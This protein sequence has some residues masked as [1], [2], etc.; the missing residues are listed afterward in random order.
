MKREFNDRIIRDGFPDRWFVQD[1]LDEKVALLCTETPGMWPGSTCICLK[2]A[3]ITTDE[4]L[5]IARQIARGYDARP[6]AS[7]DVFEIAGYVG[8][9]SLEMLIAGQNAGCVL[10]HAPLLH[11]EGIP[12][13]RSAALTTKGTAE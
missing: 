9:A 4:W 13:Y 10:H 1:R 3:A 5:P 7:V 12:L 8:K 11:A 2:P 6:P